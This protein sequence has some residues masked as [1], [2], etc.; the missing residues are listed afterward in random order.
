MIYNKFFLSCLGL[1]AGVAAHAATIDPDMR[2]GELPNGFT[3]YIQHTDNSPGTADYFLALNVGSVN[4]ED[5]QR[6]LA[7]F[8]EHLC[9][10]GTEHFPG[11]SLISYLEN[12]GVKFGAHLNA[13]TSTDETV[14]N[15]CKAPTIRPT[16][17]DSCLL[18]LRDWCSGLSLEDSEIE[19]ERGVIVNEWRQR[20]SASNRMLEKASPKLYGGSPYGERLPIG[21]MEVVE[22]FKPEV[23]RQF[24]NKWHVPC[25]QAVIIVGD[26][27]ADKVERKIKSLMGKMPAR[28]DANAKKAVLPEVPVA[29]SL[30]CV[31][32]SDPEQGTSMLQMY[33]RLPAVPPDLKSAL[34]RKIAADM[35]A[36]ILAARFDFYESEGGCPHLSLGIGETKYIMSRGETALTLRGIV[37]TGRETDATALWYGELLRTLQHGVS[38][39]EIEKA[40]TNA[41]AALDESIRKAKSAD[42]TANARKAVRHFLDGGHKISDDDYAEIM[43]KTIAGT[44]ADDVI[45]YL[46]EAVNISGVGAVILCYHPR[47]AKNDAEMETMLRDRFKATSGMTFA[48]YTNERKNGTLMAKEPVGGAVVTYDSIREFDA[49][50]YTLSNGIKLVTKKTDYKP[51]QIYI[52][53]FAPG[54]LS[55]QYEEEKAPTM[56]VINELMAEMAY[57]GHTPAEI[58]QM[59]SGYNVKASVNVGN[60]EEVVE[61]STNRNDLETALKFL[62]LRTTAFEPDSVA[63]ANFVETRRADV[64]RR[65]LS[66]VQAMGDSI[67]YNIYSRHPLA[68]RQSRSDIDKIDMRTAFNIYHDCFADM[69]DFTFMIVG[70]FDTDTLLTLS[71][72]YLGALPSTQRHHKAVGIGYK[73]TPNDFSIEFEREMENP[74]SIVYNF[75]SGSCDYSLENML[76]A[77]VFGQILRSRLLAELRERRAWS[78][79]VKAHCAINAGVD[80]DDVPQVMCPTYVKVTPGTEAATLDIIRNTIA[81]L[82]TKGNITEEEVAGIREFLLKNH[83]ETTKD[84]A[85]WL[86][87][88][89]TYIRD[90]IDIESGFE[91]AV[92]GI[93]ASGV[94]EFVSRYITPANKASI[95]MKASGRS[96]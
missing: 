44:D 46:T 65:R 72:R 49:K 93:D 7:H 74:Q 37:K 6:G 61:A 88:L 70:D 4:E 82:A 27:D 18:I 10:N 78:Y 28:R 38:Q 17:V 69:G 55:R 19:A 15:I 59:L 63:F 14:Y 81:G 20:R 56:R 89:K 95:I 12:I 33:F 22:N 21:I 58:R 92:N 62:Y 23:L 11:N 5:N 45:R 43:R 42:N 13:Y 54:G 86:K 80:A 53:G 60:F 40:K 91:Q 48:P 34:K 68:G 96:E 75:V 3:Y 9:F 57:G 77:T 52:R 29:D 16:T 87:V 67:H 76:S 64:D 35:L 50:V 71:S 73:Y 41:L 25:N 39:Q 31:V 83:A 36:D 90:G 85:Y 47:D 79:S 1:A 66:P 24:Y 26:V 32:E 30:L 51:G 8:L 84:N 94:K 2:V